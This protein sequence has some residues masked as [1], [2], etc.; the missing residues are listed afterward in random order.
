LG[1]VRRGIGN[2]FMVG[3]L[4]WVGVGSGDAGGGVLAVAVVGGGVYGLLHF[5]NYK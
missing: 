1:F 3:L 4:G 2:F 5:W